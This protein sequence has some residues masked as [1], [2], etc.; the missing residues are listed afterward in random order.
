M[1][2]RPNIYESSVSPLAGSKMSSG[3]RT[4]EFNKRRGIYCV[5]EQPTAFQEKFCPK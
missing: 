4:F 3:R 1:Y 5:A 2:N